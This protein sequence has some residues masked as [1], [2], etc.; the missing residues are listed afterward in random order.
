MYTK[1]FIILLNYKLIKNYTGLTD[2]LLYL[3]FPTYSIWI[4]IYNYYYYNYFNS[5][6][7]YNLNEYFLRIKRT[8]AERNCDRKRNILLIIYFIINYVYK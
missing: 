8:K 1:L 4:I 6:F 5:F 3:F 7:V 2:L